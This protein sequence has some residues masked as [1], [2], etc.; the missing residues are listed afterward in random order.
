MES[1]LNLSFLL[2][3]TQRTNR[4]C[5]FGNRDCIFANRDLLI[6]AYEIE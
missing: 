4:D 6:F 5:F 2:C 3:L 1:E